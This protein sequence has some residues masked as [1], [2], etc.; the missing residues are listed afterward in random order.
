MDLSPKYQ[1][2]LVLEEDTEELGGST[3]GRR[4]TWVALVEA[5]MGFF[6]QDPSRYGNLPYAK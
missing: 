3:L 5:A 6:P 2:M 4:S 1:T